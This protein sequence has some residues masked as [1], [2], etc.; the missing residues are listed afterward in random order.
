MVVSGAGDGTVLWETA[1]GR[2][3]RTLGGP[4]GPVR[5][6]GFSPDGSMIVS[7]ADDRTVRLWETATG[8]QARTLAGHTRTVSSV[9]FSPDGSM[10]VS[11]AGDGTVRL[12]ETATGRQIATMIGVRDGRA[13]LPPHSSYKLVGEPD[14]A[15]WWMIK[16]VR[17]EPGELD[18]HDPT[19]R[20]VPEDAPLALPAG[21]HPITPPV[22]PPGPRP[23]RKGGIFRRR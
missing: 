4:S 20:R 2:Q 1:T 9:G 14:G 23:S 19:V 7:G 8:R 17:F 5:S 12:W 13:I 3:L 22:A 15:F 16:C 11:G 6:V 18:Q 21:W 10:I